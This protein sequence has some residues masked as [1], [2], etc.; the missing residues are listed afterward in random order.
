MHLRLCFGRFLLS[1]RYETNRPHST[2]A[3]LLYGAGSPYTSS[4]HKLHVITTA[5]LHLV[6]SARRNPC[7]PSLCKP[8][9]AKHLASSTRRLPGLSFSHHGIP[10]AVDHRHPLAAPPHS[11]PNVRPSVPFSSV[12]HFTSGT[13]ENCPP[14]LEDSKAALLRNCNVW[15]EEHSTGGKRC[16]ISAWTALPSPTPYALL[17]SFNK[18]SGGASPPKYTIKAGRQGGCAHVLF[19]DYVL[20]VALK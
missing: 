9:H 13:H 11:R 6:Y 3:F 1:F 4:A 19:I 5:T 2:T 18:G 15:N 16:V 17:A 12:I 7:D 8:H 10:K 14:N 20:C